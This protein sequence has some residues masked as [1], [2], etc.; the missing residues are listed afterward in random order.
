MFIT[1]ASALEEAL[2]S[3]RLASQVVDARW[4]AFV[5]AESDTRRAAFALYLAALDA[6]QAAAEDLEVVAR[7]R[8]A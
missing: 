1:Y 5:H 8:A 4:D 3:W 6:E 7:R 2:E